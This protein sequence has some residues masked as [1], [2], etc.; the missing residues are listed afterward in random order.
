M[1]FLLLALA[2]VAALLPGP[3]PAGAE[4]TARAACATTATSGFRPVGA[5]VDVLGREFR[6]VR[7]RRT[8]SGAIGTPPVTAAGKTMV[9]W[10]RGIRPG[11]GV[12]SV[13]LD[14]HTWPDGSALGNALLSRLRAGH[15]FSLRAADGRTV[16]YRVRARRSYPAARVPRS[17]AFR[18]WGPEQAVIVV[19][20]G[21]RL[22]P[23]RWARRTVWYAEPLAVAAR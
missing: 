5:R 18:T 20:S 22:G 1:R 13:I 12:G 7:V 8:A 9:G 19:C 4:P 17:K 15:T 2:T 14:A 3:A 6:V 11:E 23:G 16:C 21:R 10:D